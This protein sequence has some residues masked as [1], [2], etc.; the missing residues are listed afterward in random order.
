MQR[1]TR[2]RRRPRRNRPKA[3]GDTIP[4]SYA[5]SRKFI[6]PR[7][8]TTQNITTIVHSEPIG[9]VINTTDYTVGRYTINPGDPSFNWL[10]GQAE[11]WELWRF[12]NFRVRYEPY[13]ATTVSGQ[14]T[15]GPEYSA[16]TAPPGS[17]VALRN[18]ADST[19]GPVYREMEIKLNPRAAFPAGGFK[20]VRHNNSPIGE[21]KLYDA[22]ELMVATQH[23]N[24]AACG[25]LI[26]DYR[27]QFKSPQI[28]RPLAPASG[29]LILPV[30]HRIG[31]YKDVGVDHRLEWGDV[32]VNTVDG[33]AYGPASAGGGSSFTLQPGTYR[34]H[35]KTRVDSQVRPA[36][37]ATYSE[38][39]RLWLE[40]VTTNA[41]HELEQNWQGVGESWNTITKSSKMVMDTV[42]FISKAT[43]FYMRWRYDLDGAT[44]STGLLNIPGD[45][46]SSVIIY[47]LQTYNQIAQ[48]VD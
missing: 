22:C 11:S 4:A 16:G 41:I 24:N 3:A 27:I 45:E 48:E 17:M 15:M 47:A 32:K 2:K 25:M 36:S 5:V 20:Y 28:E 19:S 35:A 38:R 10:K 6:K 42:I 39:I 7:I 37:P 23:G 46:S 44:P 29:I 1:E 34:I 21:P 18:Y 14:L 8:K 43:E 13:V 33:A 26:M 31:D 12:V 9:D 30:L 40:E